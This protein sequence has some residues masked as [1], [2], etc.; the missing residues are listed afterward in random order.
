ML[1]WQGEEDLMV[2]PTHG[3]WLLAHVPRPEGGVFPGE[4]HLTL[5][6]RSGDLLAWLGDRLA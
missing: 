2:P 4:G 5:V 6:H 1:V 3:H